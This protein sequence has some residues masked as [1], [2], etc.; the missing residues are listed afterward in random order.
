MNYRSAFTIV[1]GFLLAGVTSQAQAAFQP[2]QPLDGFVGLDVP[3]AGVINLD[4]LGNIS[5]S[6]NG[7]FGPYT[8]TLTHIASTVNPAW[9]DV[10]N[11]PLEVTSYEVVGKGGLVPIQ[12]A[13][14]SVG[15]TEGLTGP[16]SDVL[17]FTPLSIDGQGFGHTRIDFLSDNEAPFSFNTDV[18]VAEINDFAVYQAQSGY[19]NGDNDEKM[20]YNIT[21]NVD[22]VVPE[23]ASILVWSL[24]GGL[25]LTAGWYW[26]R[27]GEEKGSERLCRKLVVDS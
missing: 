27:Q 10:N 22:A 16:L 9:V 14:G 12:L 23:P 15:L 17:I 18:N 24:L 6:F 19:A 11:A 21:S 8:V 1:L 26:R 13:G 5:G 20:T 4:E 25:G 7:F 2:G 3:G